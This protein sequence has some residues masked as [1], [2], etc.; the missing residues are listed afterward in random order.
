MHAIQGELSFSLELFGDYIAEREGYKENDG[1]EAIHFYVVNK[2]HWLPSV[3]Q[4]MSHDDLRFVLSEEMSGWTLPK[5]ARN[6]EP[7]Y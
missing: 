1:L 7:Q 6:L 5:D 4:S 3:V 2:F